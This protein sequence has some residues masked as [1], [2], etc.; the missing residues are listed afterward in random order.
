MILAVFEEVT[1]I[2]YVLR[3]H[4]VV[5]VIVLLNCDVEGN[6]GGTNKTMREMK[7]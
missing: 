3:S 2:N 6:S 4:T 7:V 5:E 1:I